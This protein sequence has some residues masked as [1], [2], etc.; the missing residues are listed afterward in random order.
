M[1][2][3]FLNHIKSQKNYAQHTLT[4][5]QKDLDFLEVYL[6]NTFEAKL[7]D[8]N[9][10]MLRSW[11]VDMAEGHYARSTIQRKVSAAKSFYNF[12]NHRGMIEGN[13]AKLIKVPGK[14]KKLPVFLTERQTELL[15]SEEQFS[16]DFTGMRDRLIVEVLYQTGMRRAELVGLK[17]HDF[18]LSGGSV[19]ITGKGNKQRIIPLNKN[20]LSL[21]NKYTSLKN[22]VCSQNTTDSFFVTR[23]GEAIYSKL[24]Y[25]VVN[26]YLQQV[27]TATK[28]SPHVLRHTFA[29]HMLNNGADINAVKE[30]L[31]HSSLA[32][33]QVYTH[34]TIDKIKSIYKQ[35]HPRA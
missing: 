4:A 20:L 27:S 24:V 31:G 15:T 33:T 34:N 2:K 14:E 8:A 7:E 12:L 13:P 30:I 1:K 10:D 28:K 19:K 22:D 29:T 25:R 23:K 18:D 9:S 11:L 6:N 3:A 17:S 26:H 16:D 21:V 5:Y 32:A 35:A